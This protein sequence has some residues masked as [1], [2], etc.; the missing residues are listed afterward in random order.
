MIKE[1]K[2][3]RRIFILLVLLIFCITVIMYKLFLIQIKDT[4]NY[5]KY[6]IDLLEKSI[7]QR[8]QEFIVSSGR[9]NIYDRNLESLIKQEE[10][11]TLIV[12]PFIK[13]TINLDSIKI[14]ANVIDIDYDNLLNQIKSTETPKYIIKNDKPVNIS[15][16][17]HLKIEQLNPVG[18]IVSP[19]TVQDYENVLTKHVVGYM[20]Q[21]PDEIIDRYKKYLEQGILNK[22]SLIGRSGLQMTFE[23]ILMGI[24]ESSIAYFVDNKGNPLNGL[25][26]NY[27]INNDSYYPLSLVT[28][29][30]R[31]IQL[32]SEKTLKK[33]EINEGSIVVLDVANGDIIAM[34]SV[35]DFNLLNVDPNSPNWNNKAVQVT[36]PGSIFKIVVA[37]AALEEGLVTLE[38]EFYCSGEY[39]YKFS[40]HDTHGRITFAEGFAQS[41]NT[42]FA[43]VAK[44]LGSEVIEDYARKL[45]VIDTVGWSGDF[46]KNDS[47]KQIANEEFNR[48]FHLNTVRDDTGSLIRT[49]IGQQDVRL[50]PLAAAN[51]I[52]TILNEGKTYEPRLVGKIVYKN[53]IDYY[54]FPLHYKKIDDISEETYAKI[55]YLMGQVVETGTGY[56]LKDATWPLAGKSGT[57]ETNNNLNNQ[58]F[59]GYGPVKNPEYAIAV[60]VKNVFQSTSLAQKVFLD[61]TNELAK[62]ERNKS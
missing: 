22:N 57:A 2:S 26:T 15:E 5:S 48:V 13:N 34:A 14:L 33:Y 59:I 52:V 56:L 35:P 20:S 18:I 60:L 62:L 58:W 38:E 1:D 28:T 11:K 21:A 46:F 45:G 30:D 53:G 42:V 44:R 7:Q 4:R 49:A 16:E 31:E 41:C 43:E 23:E 61:L 37:I 17:Q 6:H 19:Y 3:K 24:G 39:D 32:I 55:K 36:E 50:S 29:I 51:L 8:E 27:Q 40:C 25:S 47:F 12:F 10:I 9:G 54:K